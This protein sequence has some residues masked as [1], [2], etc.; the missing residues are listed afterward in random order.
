[1]P[2]AKITM[3]LGLSFFFGLAFEG[4][5]AKSEASRPGGIR[6]FPLI[7]LCGALLYSFE[8][9][10]A[11]AFC[12]GLVV[13][14]IW[15]YP[16]YQAEVTRG[17]DGEGISDGIMVP[18]C[19]LVAYV[20]GPVALTFEP[21]VAFGLAV[22]AVLLLQARDRLHALAQA[23]P[24]AE[25]ITLGQFL[26]LTGIVLPLL[27]NTPVTTLTPIT[28]FQVW[29]AVV[30]VSS[31]SY[32]SYV[33]Q[34]VLTARRSLFVTAML[35]GLYS[36]TA[37]TVV[38]AQRL[39]EDTAANPAQYRAAIVLATA[40]MY[41]RLL[42]MVAIFSLAIAGHLALSL[43]LLCGLGLALAAA[44]L[45]AG[46]G[47]VSGIVAKPPP[48]SNPLELPAALIFAVL[49]VITSIASAWVIQSFGDVGVYWLAGIVG[50][51]D[52]DPFVLSLAQG[53]VAG[54]SIHAAAM[55]I[56]IA[57]SSNNLLKAIYAVAFA[58]WQRSR[59]IVVALVVLS[60]AG[61]AAAA[62]LV[63]HL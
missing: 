30:V 12:V 60:A 2:A 48:P 9:H 41:L 16:Y 38:L 43:A 15:L 31:L 58:G 32:G 63:E 4:F 39:K 1:M 13:L 35:G 37:T 23:L 17:I 59:T 34:K 56:L 44:C 3:L 53:G 62:W 42:I 29:L 14:G 26:I 36:S 10:Y 21:W 49:F 46:S 61:F 19:N 45:Y 8:P 52:I 27:P 20:L 28:P 25:V 6:T 18:M 5:Y 54:L 47:R 50:V 11:I 55:A 40:L 22:A 57:A 7:S 24:G 51:T 33:L